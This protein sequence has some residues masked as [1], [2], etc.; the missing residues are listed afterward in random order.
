VA[1]KTGLGGDQERT[2]RHELGAQSVAFAE[3]ET[4]GA[5]IGGERGGDQ[6]G[7]AVGAEEQWKRTTQAAASSTA[8]R[9]IVASTRPTSARPVSATMTVGMERTP[10]ATAAS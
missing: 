7:R 2:E 5:A 8:A 1:E 10:S 4:D 9:Y 3:P 6:P